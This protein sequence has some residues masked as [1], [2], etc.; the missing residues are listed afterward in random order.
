MAEDSDAWM[1]QGSDE[2]DRELKAHEAEMDAAPKGAKPKAA[3]AGSSTQ[4]FDAE[5]LA[6]RMQVPSLQ[7]VLVML[8]L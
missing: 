3:A 4:D 1:A 5:E 7:K 2:V 6:R 8:S